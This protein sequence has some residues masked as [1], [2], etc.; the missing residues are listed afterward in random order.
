[1]KKLSE[2]VELSDFFFQDKLIFDKDILQ[3]K[4]VGDEAQ[5]ILENLEKIIIRK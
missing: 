5:K 3:W 4:G 1:M 2:I